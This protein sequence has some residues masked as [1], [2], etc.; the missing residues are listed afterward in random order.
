MVLKTVEVQI[1]LSDFE[2]EA[3]LQE[4]VDRSQAEQSAPEIRSWLLEMLSPDLEPLLNELYQVQRTDQALF[5]GH[6][7]P[8]EVQRDQLLAKLFDITLGRLL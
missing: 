5:F 7:R 3:L 4:L 6:L 8:H 1:D 2:T